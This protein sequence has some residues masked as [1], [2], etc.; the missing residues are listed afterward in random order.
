M[1]V[2]SVCPVR[3]AYIDQPDRLFFGAAAGASAQSFRQPAD[4]NQFLGLAELLGIAACVLGSWL[5]AH[6]AAALDPAEI[7][8]ER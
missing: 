3:Q 2:F 8:H 5:P 6:V 4:G 7:L 1:P